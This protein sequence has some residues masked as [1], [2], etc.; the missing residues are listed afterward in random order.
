MVSED[1][2]QS[3][4]KLSNQHCISKRRVCI[5]PSTIFGPYFPI[6]FKNETTKLNYKRWWL[7]D[8]Y[9]L[10]AVWML[11]RDAFREAIC[12]YWTMSNTPE[13]LPLQEHDCLKESYYYCRLVSTLTPAVNLVI[14]AFIGQVQIWFRCI[15]Q[16]A[17]PVR[18]P[19]PKRRTKTWPLLVRYFLCTWLKYTKSPFKQ[20]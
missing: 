3:T 6:V 18:K 17:Y 1:D 12:T 5:L 2:K 19:H 14:I 4:I 8:C 13:K 15:F 16:R 7:P 9:H 11:V 20:K 10:S